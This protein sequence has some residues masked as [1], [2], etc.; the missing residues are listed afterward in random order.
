M[1]HLPTG[2]ARPEVWGG[3]ECTV[4][5]VGDRYFDQGH[6]N[7]H[8]VREDDLDRLRDLGIR[9]VRSPVLWARIEV[10]PGEYD[11]TWTDRRLARLREHGIDPIAPWCT[12]AAV[13]PGPAW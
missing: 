8:D 2:L 11:W 4:N 6:L 13:R 9:A 5:R 10:R 1:S 7:G 12:T 3:L